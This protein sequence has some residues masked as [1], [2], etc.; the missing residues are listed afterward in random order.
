MFE[1][2]H[3]S[4][5]LKSIIEAFN[6]S[7]TYESVNVITGEYCESQKDL[8]VSKTLDV[9][10][11]YH[12]KDPQAMG[13]YVNQPNLIFPNTG[14]MPTTS[15]DYE[16]DDLK[17]LTKVIS[18][19]KWLSISYPEKLKCHIEDPDGNWVEY[20]VKDVPVNREF[21]PLIIENVLFSSGKQQFYDYRDH[22]TERRKLISKCSNGLGNYIQTEYYDRTL[23][24]VG[25]DLVR[26]DN[27]PRDPRTGAVKLQK[28]PVGRDETP[29]ITSRYFYYNGYTE[30]FNAL[31]NKTVY[32]Y[33]TNQKITAIQNYMGRN[34]YRVER[35]EWDNKDFLKKKTIEDGAG[36]IHRIEEFAYDLWGNVVKH[37]II[38]NI[39]GTERNDEKYTTVFRYSADD[40]HNLVYHKSDNG[41][42]TKYFYKDGTP[43]LIAKL[44]YDFDRIRIR[45]FYTYDENGIFVEAIQDDG[46]TED[47]DNTTGVTERH[48]VQNEIPKEKTIDH[49]KITN[50]YDLAHRLIRE[51]IIEEG[52]SDVVNSYLYDYNGNCISNFDIFGNETTHEYDS[53]GREIKTTTPDG[54]IT[55]H[56]FDIFD[57]ITS[58]TD[59]NGYTTFTQY[60]FHGKPILVKHPDGATEYFQYYLDGSLKKAIGKDG[61]YTI[62]TR[63][64]MSRIVDTNF[65]AP[66]GTLI[67]SKK[68][69]YNSFHLISTINSIGLKTHYKYDVEGRL[70]KKT[71]GI[72]T[73]EYGYDEYGALKWQKDWWKNEYAIIHI[74]ENGMTIE[75]SSG[76]ILKKIEKPA[77]N[78]EEDHISYTYGDFLQKVITNSKGSTTIISYDALG[79]EE[80]IEQKDLFG[81]MVA[82]KT[83]AYDLAGNK[84]REIYW[85]PSGVL[86]TSY[87][88]GPGGRIESVAEGEQA[89]FFV[90]N[91]LGQL[92]NKIKPDG[93]II[94]SIYMPG[95]SL[96]EMFASDHSFHYVYEYDSEGNVIS[97]F[98]EIDGT[99][100]KRTL[101]KHNQV[102]QE[103][104][105]NGLKLKF[106][107]D[108]LGRRTRILLPDNS[109][110]SYEYNIGFM[111]S[112]NRI[113]TSNQILYSHY[114]KEYNLQGKATLQQLLGNLGNLNIACNEEGRTLSQRSEYLEESII[115]DNSKMPVE[116]IMNGISTKFEYDSLNQIIGESNFTYD[117]DSLQNR[118]EKNGVLY[119]VNDLNEIVAIENELF[120]YD[121]NGNMI[122][123]N[124]TAMTYDALNRLK[125]VSKDDLKVS[126]IYDSFGR[127]LSKSVQK[128]S[129]IRNIRFMYEG[130]NE[131]G[132]VDEQGNIIEFRV[133]G[134]GNGS[135]AGAAISIEIGGK[136]YAPIHD[137]RGSVR[138]LVSMETGETIENYNYTAFGEESTSDDLINSWRYCSKRIDSETGLVYFGKRY[139]AP[140]LG[141]WITKDPLGNPEGVNRYTYTMNN[142]MVNHDLYG[143]FSVSELFGRIW[144]FIGS[145]GRYAYHLASNIKHHVSF[146]EYIRPHFENV[147]QQI[148]GKGPLYLAGFYKD[149]SETGVHGKGEILDKVRITLINGILNARIDYKET[150]DFLSETHGG[151]NVHYVFNATEGWT[152][153]ILNAVAA[154]FGYVSPAAHML[155]ETW[156]EMIHEM[157]GVDGGGQILHYAHSIGGTHTYS[158]LT[159]MTPEELKMINI[160]TI[161]SATLFSHSGVGSIMN[162]ISRR[163]GVALLDPV[164]YFK[165]LLGLNPNTI[166]IGSWAGIPLVDHMLTSQTYFD[167]IEILGQR[168]IQHYFMP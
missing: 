123:R 76:N 111:K 139:Y 97:V 28:G 10:R 155:A 5:E 71:D 49:K 153:D 114:Y 93:T 46:T 42:S 95:G 25:G 74:E 20:V 40:M 24:D 141:R 84:L 156:K 143:L 43:Q 82:K 138:C 85:T 12:S 63:D 159:L 34:F 15:G 30:V 105:G 27:L 54:A 115:Y 118:I 59:P 91:L 39:T 121:P 136:V 66:D 69:N 51:E 62:Y 168:F 8:T 37:T 108:N 41:V 3:A 164:G 13:W 137:S 142:P 52:R 57:R 102:I 16:F 64:F 50:T 4:E 127:R 112:V 154:K 166:F 14:I 38:G 21:Q 61:S 124:N 32:R 94:T 88:Y 98:N 79:R 135:E 144:N 163:D 47:R 151:N 33:G 23:N 26:I 152:G 149:A 161:G 31:N 18:N 101:N 100:T 35:F 29:I 60:N 6:S 130:E 90:Y 87:S 2:L 117:Y 56:E 7:H 125:T 129:S 78:P 146:E 86:T 73:V 128:G 72:Q 53:L 120:S 9:K 134:R 103:T 104:L 165:G 126:F 162:F 17:R 148:I 107:Y 75:D 48:K 140:D 122:K 77:E 160:V 150:I 109:E 44:T 131:I 11:V 157:G 133:L 68:N 58:T 119:N 113:S 99:S 110:V 158:A 1:V 147:A 80:A 89:T 22:P 36:H 70:I 83:Y 132:S 145:V 92:E 96:S 81:Q 65:F 106:E 19:D 116:V 167:L 45:E 55:S 67:S